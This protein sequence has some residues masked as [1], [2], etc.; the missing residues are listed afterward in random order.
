MRQ[1]KK[2]RLHSLTCND[3]TNQVEYWFS[4]SPLGFC[5]QSLSA[6]QIHFEENM[7]ASL[8]GGALLSATLQVVFD[9][10]ASP[11]VVDYLRGK[12]LND[13]L[14]N[15]LK[16]VLSAV[17]AVLDD[18]E[19]KQITNPNVKQWLDELEDA[20]LD[21]D[22]LLDEIAT[23]ALQSK[24]EAGSGTSNTSK[25]IINFFSNSLNIYDRKMKNKLEEILKRLKFLEERIYVLGLIKGVG[26]KPLPRP[27]TTSLIEEDEVYGRDGDKEAIIKL[28]IDDGR[29]TKVSVIPIVGM[30]GVGKTTL[31]QLVY[32]HDQVKEHFG[33]K[34]WICVS[35]EFDIY[36]VTKTILCAVTKSHSY[37]NIDLDSLQNKLKEVLM[38]QKYL[39]VLDDVW[40]ENYVNWENMS[41][42]FKH[43][44]Q[45]SK[46]LVTTRNESVAKIMQTV[47]AYYLVHL[48]DEDC[49]QL[50]AKLAFHN[51]DFAAHPALEIIGRKIVKKCKGLPLAVKTLGGL[52]RSTVNVEEWEKILAS[53]IWH[54]SGNESNILP[55]LRLSYHHLPSHLKRCFAFCAIFPEDHIFRKHDLVLLWMA[56]NFLQQSTRNKRMEDVGDEYFNELVSRSFFQR[57][58]RGEEY[59]VMHDLIHDLARHVSRNNCLTLA[60]GNS[61]EVLMVKVRHLA[62]ARFDSISEA[63]CLRTLLPTH[64]FSFDYSSDEVVNHAILKSRCLRVL[65]L[66]GCRKLKRLPESIGEQRHLRHLDLSMTSI[67][68]LPEST[69]CQD[70]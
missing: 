59:F 57:S 21:A 24:L 38:G 30:G 42:P 17:N 22:D 9:R 55:A 56:E 12:R 28:L 1:T 27:P 67:E 70:I 65:S 36:K 52:L 39:I 20:S 43:G 5:F 11:E 23:D 3:K 26:E 62:I 14:I 60:D 25:S 68:R 51:E 41:R 31:A 8:V 54:L 45:G 63:A 18:A 53:E 48:K 34:A 64:R 49:W 50:F 4:P 58:N 7:A 19:E 44:A 46:I 32:N 15:N 61:E 6:V 35:E 29:S 13:E 69:R 2:E 33:F 66:Y 40:N 10:L 47:P 16:T 37:D